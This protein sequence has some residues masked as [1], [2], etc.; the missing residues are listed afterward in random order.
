MSQSGSKDFAGPLSL[1]KTISL[2]S[3]CSLEQPPNKLL[4]SI[5]LMRRLGS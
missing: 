2:D 5:Q 3:K 1:K 4:N